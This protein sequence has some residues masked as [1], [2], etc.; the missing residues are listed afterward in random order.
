MTHNQIDM[1]R[2]HGP[3]RFLSIW[4]PPPTTLVHGSTKIDFPRFCLAPHAAHYDCYYFSIHTT[5]RLVMQHNG[6]MRNKRSRKYQNANKVNPQP[7]AQQQLL[8]FDDFLFVLLKNVIFVLIVMMIKGNE[9]FSSKVVVV[10][11][12]AA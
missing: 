12:V 6:E 5:S 3:F 9:D 10:V 7:R 2:L 11:V 1:T 8:L 4:P